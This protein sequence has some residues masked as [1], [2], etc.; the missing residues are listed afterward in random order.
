MPRPIDIAKKLELTSIALKCLTRKEL[1]ARF[2]TINPDTALTLQSSYN[3]LRGRSLPRSFGVYEDW[4]AVLDLPE[5]AHFIMSSSLDDFVRALTRKIDLPRE[6][7]DGIA[8]RPD[9]PAVAPQPAGSPR[10]IWRNGALLTG[11]FLA[12]SPAWSPTQRGRLLIGAL[13]LHSRDG[14]VSAE[15]VE[16]VLHRTLRFTGSGI[17]DG[18]TGQLTLQCDANAGTFLMAF[19]LPLLPGNLAAGVF[20]GITVYD[21]NSEPTASPILFLRIHGLAAEA[22]VAAIGYEDATPAAL[23]PW[24]DKIG[25][26][27]AV[28]LELETA[29]LDLLAGSPNGPLLPLQRDRMSEVAMLLDRRHLVAGHAHSG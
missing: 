25:Y 20:A 10:P 18:R 23:A 6:L 2:R 7:L 21:P 27:T 15:Y 28:D 26:G 22:L 12:L 11:Q 24:L 13:S 17:E 14:L 29:L 4:A 5:G 16:K 9:T 8:P 19:H 3:W 1:C